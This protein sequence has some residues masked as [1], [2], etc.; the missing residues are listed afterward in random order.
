MR[1]LQYFFEEQAFGVCTRLGEIL[2]ISTSSIRLFFIYAS[3]LTFG[4]PL[5]VYL[6][7]AFIMNLRRHLRKQYNQIRS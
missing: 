1:K 2:H 6:G 4:S 5:F 3:F 7:L